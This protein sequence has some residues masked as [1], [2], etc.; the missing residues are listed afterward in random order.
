MQQSQEST[1]TM[2]CDSMNAKVGCYED[3]SN[4]SEVS[5]L[6]LTGCW[7]KTHKVDRERCH[8][9]ADGMIEKVE[10]PKR[11]TNSSVAAVTSQFGCALQQ[12]HGIEF[13][14][15]QNKENCMPLTDWLKK[16]FT[17]PRALP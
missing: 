3:D 9:N 17:D 11:L 15:F 6:L 16:K 12:A 4:H 13:Q 14:A 7:W 10:L 1:N 5:N 2:S 8:E